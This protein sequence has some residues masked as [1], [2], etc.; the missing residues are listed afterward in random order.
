M[1]KADNLERFTISAESES[2]TKTVVETRDF[3]FI[4]DEPA[5]LGGTNSG[6]NPVE[7]LISA[8]A[9]CLNVVVH[10]VSEE[11]EIDL[12]SVEIEI[13]GDLDPRKFLGAAEDVRAGYQE[14]QVQIEVESDADE[15]TLNAL[16]AEVEERCPVGDNIGNPTPTN[17][18]I[19]ASE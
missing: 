17:V 15:E 18:I 9:G 12:D 19:E 3:E 4:V 11:R 16:C 1:S 2:E 7:Y 14:L 10:T 8:W 5:A 13:Q 6:P